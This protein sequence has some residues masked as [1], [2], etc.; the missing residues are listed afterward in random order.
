[1][2][3]CPA[4]ATGRAFLPSQAWYIDFEP[5]GL[6]RDDSDDPSGPGILQ[7]SDTIRRAETILVVATFARW[8][9]CA[10]NFLGAV[11]QSPCAHLF[12]PEVRWA[13]GTFQSSRGC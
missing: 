6:G 10:L 2:I 3:A 13:G 9:Y 7:A 4:R 5:S 11:D 12:R 1:M 8:S